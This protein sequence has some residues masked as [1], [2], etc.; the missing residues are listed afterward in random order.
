MR[1]ASLFALFLGLGAAPRLF[2]ADPIFDPRVLHET[3]I[4]MDPADW[5]A[6]RDNFRTNQYYAANVS[7]DGEVIEQ[8]GLRSRG[9]GSRDPNKPGL[10]VDFN[11]F[12]R[13]R[14]FHAL[15]SLV[16]DNEIQDAS[17]LREPLAYA[18]FQAMGIE[19]P[20]IA[21][22]RLTINGAYWGV[23]AQTEDVRKAF[24]KQRFG[25][26]DDGNLF[27]YEWSGA[28]DFSWRGE[29]P[30]E[31]VPDPFEPQTNEDSLDATEL[32]DFIRTINEAPDA[33]FLAQIANYIDVERFLTYVAVENALAESDGLLGDQGMNNFYLYQS[34]DGSR[35]T[36]IP[37]DKDNSFQLPQWPVDRGVERNVLVRRLLG[38]PAQRTFYVE[39]VR[40]TVDQYVNGRWLLPR[41]EANYG[42]IREA[43]L[44]DTRKPQ[45]NDQFEV[46]VEGL[47][48]VIDNRAD[49]VNLQLRRSAAVR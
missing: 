21:Y 7:F 11:R 37:W 31:Y 1:L 41:L 32:V 39:A 30:S 8:V 17:L 38:F 33:A 49:D 35:F 42:L 2:A 20:Q 10:R 48:G 46:A 6:L 26:D 43:A 28:Y 19:A 12:G 27:A 36:F 9:K 45:S 29:N 47:R 24:L 23:Y 13:D 3:R 34:E 25:S 44:A 16:L 18:V 5:Q 22:T 15:K 14:E 4:E 40:R